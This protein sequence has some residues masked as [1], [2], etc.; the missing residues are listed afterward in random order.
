MHLPL[1]LSFF[2]PRHMFSAGVTADSRRQSGRLNAQ[3]QVLLLLLIQLLRLLKQVQNQRLNVWFW[4]SSTADIKSKAMSA[5][6]V[7]QKQSKHWQSAQWDQHH[8]HH[9]HHQQSFI[10]SFAHSAVLVGGD[11]WYCGCYCTHHRRMTRQSHLAFHLVLLPTTSCHFH[12][13][14]NLVIAIA[15]AAVSSSEHTEWP[16]KQSYNTHTHSCAGAMQTI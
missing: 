9:H 4:R 3:W 16:G 11:C 13:T 8:C 5:V 14:F 6:I 2:F 10:H 7:I 1:S 15:A 12:C